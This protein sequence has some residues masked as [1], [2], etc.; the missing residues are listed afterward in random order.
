MTEAEKLWR[1][2]LIA[3]AIIGILLIVALLVG[4]DEQ[5]DGCKQIRTDKYG[6]RVCEDRR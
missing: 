2:S 5:K 6:V 4:C 3:L 1:G